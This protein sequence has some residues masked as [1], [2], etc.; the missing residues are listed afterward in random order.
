MKIQ[1]LITTLQQLQNE[2]GDLVVL[3]SEPNEYWG[4]ILREVHPNMIIFN[5]NA[6]YD[7]PKSVK[8]EPAIVIEV[9]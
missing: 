5:E 9:M 1:E 6:L 4:T 7:G 8:T 3:T 2:Y